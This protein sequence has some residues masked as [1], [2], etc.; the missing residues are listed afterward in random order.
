MSAPNAHI[1]GHRHRWRYGGRC[2][3]QHARCEQPL[4]LVCLDCA[5]R[6]VSR[7]GRTARSICEPC[8]DTYRRRV[9]RVFA[10]GW[11][12]N[13]FKVIVMLTVTA[14]GER[15]HALANGQR[16]ACTPDGGI[17]VGEFNALAGQYFNRLMQE[18]R[19][20]Y[21][22]IQYARA[23]EIQ[24]RGA[25]HF[26]IIMRVPRLAVLLGDFKKRNPYCALRVLVEHYGFGHEIELEPAT[27][28]AAWYCAKYV[29]KSCNDRETLPWLDT[30]TGEIAQGHG[31]YRP[32]SA[33]RR[34]GATMMAIRA[35]QAEWTRNAEAVGGEP[36]EAAAPAGATALEPNTH[37]YTS[38]EAVPASEGILAAWSSVRRGPLQ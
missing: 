18:L 14:P 19:R 32:W 24:E 28:S 9:K 8:G 27:E 12:D 11:C 15:E 35:T 6:N 36:P 7:C 23:A 34:W 2:H 22:D 17:S 10:S 31:R 16:C 3:Q 37:R 1:D 4:W 30:R 5:E 21:G 29:S 25:L 20:R 13:P 33:S 38:D 26:H